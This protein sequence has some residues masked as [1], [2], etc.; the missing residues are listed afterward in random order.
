MQTS[1][2]IVVA[3]VGMVQPLQTE[4]P[5]T[6]LLYF[7]KQQNHGTP[8]SAVIHEGTN[9]L[10]LVRAIAVNSKLSCSVCQSYI[11]PYD[12]LPS[13]ESPPW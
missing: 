4:K 3:C 13:V 9:S 2:K 5:Y 1:S 7:T 8:V 12:N 6:Q 10:L 11:A